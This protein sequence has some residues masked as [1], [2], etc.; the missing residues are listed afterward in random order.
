MSKEKR[1]LKMIEGFQCPGCTLG[2]NTQ[3]GSFKVREERNPFNG[4]ECFS[5]AS[6]SAGTFVLGLGKIYLG[7]PK[8]FCRSGTMEN[9][10]VDLYLKEEPPLWDDLNVPVWAL[11]REGFLFVRVYSPRVNQT[12][13]EVHE[14]KSMPENAIDVSKFIDEID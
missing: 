13:V 10:R 1:Q 14:D 2:H 6:H 11:K 5:C 4:A 7:L 9:M 3:C 8:G 12:R